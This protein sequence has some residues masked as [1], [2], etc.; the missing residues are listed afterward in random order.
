M[1]LFKK[2]THL[3]SII[4]DSEGKVVTIFK[5]SDDCGTSSRLA[6]KIEN[7]IV[8][9]KLEPAIY[10]VTVQ[11]EPVLSRKIEEWFDIKHESPQI[12][13]ILNG[14]VIYTSHHNNINIEE[15]IAK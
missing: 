11:T 10:M 1:R 8:T 15:F 12:I 9:R 4:E 14:K 3:S 13:T 6:D 7:E 2:T 5:Y